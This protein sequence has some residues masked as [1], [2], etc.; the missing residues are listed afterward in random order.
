[1]FSIFLAFLLRSVLSNNYCMQ[2]AEFDLFDGTKK[3]FS[4]VYWDAQ[5][6]GD[7]IVDYEKCVYF[8]EGMTG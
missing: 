3:S 2:T 5:R 8:I 1:M 4:G 6:A 7:S